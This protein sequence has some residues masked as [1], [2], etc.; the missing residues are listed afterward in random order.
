LELLTS[1]EY[2]SQPAVNTTI[3]DTYIT[4]NMDEMSESMKRKVGIENLSSEKN[5]DSPS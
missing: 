5:K 3:R 1:Y 2:P 4:I